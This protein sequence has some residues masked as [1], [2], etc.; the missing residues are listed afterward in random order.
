MLQRG[1]PPLAA[2]VLS[3]FAVAGCATPAPPAVTSLDNRQCSATPNLEGAHVVAFNPE[4]TLTINLDA[5]AACMQAGDGSKSTYAVFRLPDA[6]EPYILGVTSEPW[7][8]ALLAPRLTLLDANGATL[9][10]RASESP[11][12]H[13]SSLYVGVRARP[14]ER[15]LVVMS[16][17]RNAG[18]HISQIVGRTHATM[19]STGT[20]FMT[21]YTGSEANHVFIYAHNGV[22]TVTAKPV[23]TIN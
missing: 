15:Y 4:K 12:F 6:T 17:P 21:M 10:E 22:L 8:Q 23:P 5:S 2:C 18:Q 9:R 11:T 20:V 7:G 19:M 16:D 13:G 14:E 1:F 3:A